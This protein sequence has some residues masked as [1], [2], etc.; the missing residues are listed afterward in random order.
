MRGPAHHRREDRALVGERTVRVVADRVAQQ[1][2]VAG[3][4]R[5][6]V[7]ALVLVQPRRLEEAAVVVVGA[8]RLAVSR[9]GSAPRAALRRTA[10]CP[11]AGARRAGPAPVRRRRALRSSRRRRCR[12]TSAA[13]R[14]RCRRSTCS[15]RRRRRRTPPGRWSSCPRWLRAR[16]RTDLPDDRPPRRRSGRCRRRAW[17]G[18]TGSSCR[19]C[20]AASGAHICRCAHGTSRTCSATPQSTAS[21]VGESMRRTW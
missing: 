2:R 12:G 20:V 14:P 9:R 21:P 8:Q 19:P 3:R 17:P 10:S 11:R 13:A 4:V 5:E 15:A 7:P 1:M 6:V 16:A 18:S